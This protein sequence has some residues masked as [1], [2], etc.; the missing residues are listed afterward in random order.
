MVNALAKLHIFYINEPNVS[1]EAF[2][3]DVNNNTSNTNGFVVIMT[4][5]E[6]CTVTPTDLLDMGHHFINAPKV[7]YD[8]IPL[9]FNY[10]GIQFMNVLHLDIGK[11]HTEK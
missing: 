4:D 11:D 7:I 2:A 9:M 6:N 3:T 8:W 10:R 1:A 5:N